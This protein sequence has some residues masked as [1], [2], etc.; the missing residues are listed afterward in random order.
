MI[1]CKE[2]VGLNNKIGTCWNVAIQTNMFYGHNSDIIQK[3]L[4]ENSLEQLLNPTVIENLERFLPPFLVDDNGKLLQRSLDLIKKIVINLKKRFD[5]KNKQK[6]TKMQNAEEDVCE[7]DFVYYVMELIHPG[8]RNKEDNRWGGRDADSFFLTNILDIILLN[9]LT[10]IVKYDS[11]YLSKGNKISLNIDKIKNIGVDSHES[12]VPLDI[13]DLTEKSAN[14]ACQ[15]FECGGTT[16][17]SNNSTIIEHDWRMFFKTLNTL[18]ASD[19]DSQ[20]N[21]SGFKIFS[22]YDTTPNPLPKYMIWQNLSIGPYIIT[23]DSELKPS[24]M[25]SFSPFFKKEKIINHSSILAQGQVTDFFFSYNIQCTPENIKQLMGLNVDYYL[26]LD[27]MK[28]NTLMAQRL[29]DRIDVNV[30]DK[31]KDTIIMKS[32]RAE[33]IIFVFEA[34][35]RINETTLNNQNKKGYTA[36]M[37]ALLFKNIPVIKEVMK[38]N[39]DVTLKAENGLDVTDFARAFN[40]DLN[41]LITPEFKSLKIAI[42]DNSLAEVESLLD[43]LKYINETDSNENTILMYAVATTN[44]LEIIKAILKKNPDLSIKNLDKKTALDIAKVSKKRDMIELLDGYKSANVKPRLLKPISSFNPQVKPVKPVT[45]EPIKEEE[46]KEFISLKLAIYGK[47]LSAVESV[48]DELNDINEA[49]SKGWTPLIYSVMV[50]DNIEILKAVLKKNP[51]LSIKT[52][53]GQTA[54]DIAKL[55]G[56]KDIIEVLQGYSSKPVNV[57]PVTISALIVAI[58][59]KNINRLDSLLDKITNIN[60]THSDGLTILMHS[61]LSN[62]I[63]LV[64]AV[65]KKNPDLSI[66]TEYGETALEFAKINENNEIIKLLEDYSKPVNVNVKPINVK[67]TGRNGKC[68]IVD[69]LTVAKIN[70]VF[71]E[72]KITKPAAKVLKAE[73]LQILKDVLGC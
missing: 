39:P 38:Y 5:I 20:K 37:M 54:L 13:T 64:K 27:M 29:L 56:K 62:S 26:S 60:E 4:S 25:Y 11:V 19:Y 66:K 1:S 46:S 18:S 12:Y 69:S 43:K 24:I 23:Y 31:E 30:I 8:E 40:I 2:A 49:D 16:K 35:K 28:N 59:E 22:E 33:N 44:N 7:R 67:P 48:L 14:H 3:K 57:K 47:N 61:V 51:N 42:N 41:D 63:I 9:K 21:D 68:D 53:S 17:F 72:I 45:M 32:I 58:E 10:H 34:L 71:D 55:F 15:F 36:I 52:T 6:V 70:E 73:R 65:L 50:S